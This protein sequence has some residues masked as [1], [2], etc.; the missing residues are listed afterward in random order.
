MQTGQS[1]Y[2]TC[3]CRRVTLFQIFW[4]IALLAQRQ[5][6]QQ[7]KRF[8]FKTETLVK[9]NSLGTQFQCMYLQAVSFMR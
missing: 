9:G 7:C 2:V 3:S 5:R 8:F 4:K 6:R 1:E